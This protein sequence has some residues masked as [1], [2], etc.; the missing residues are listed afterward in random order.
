MLGNKNGISGHKRVEEHETMSNSEMYLWVR[1]PNMHPL[2]LRNQVP[3]KLSYLKD[4]LIS[5]E[6]GIMP[7]FPLTTTSFHFTE[8]GKSG[9]F[10]LLSSVSYR[11]PTPLSLI[12]E[13]VKKSHSFSPSSA[14][15][16]FLRKD[17]S[18]P[19]E[20]HYWIRS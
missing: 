18:V 3:L 2:L 13:F 14:L 10:P 12:S 4:F 20:T 9:H 15:F 7:S 19:E 5:S 16:S 11:R 8:C 6:V 1:T 17:V